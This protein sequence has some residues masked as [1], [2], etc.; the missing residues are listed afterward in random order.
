VVNIR[1]EVIEENDLDAR[2][3][4][5]YTKINNM[6]VIVIGTKGMRHT[7]SLHKMPRLCQN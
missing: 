5:D 3:K 1:N 6:D 4:I 7:I 2:S